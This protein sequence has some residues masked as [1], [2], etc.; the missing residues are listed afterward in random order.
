MIDLEGFL[1]CRKPTD[2]GGGRLRR[3]T[4]VGE[5]RVE[6]FL[7]SGLSAEVYRVTNLRFGQEGALKLLKDESRGLP[8]RFRAEADALRFLDIGALPKFLGCGFHEGVPYYVME[9]LQP[10]PEPMPRREIPSFMN[11]VAKAVQQLHDAGYIHRDLKPQNLLCRADGSPVLI[12]L[13]LVR[14]RGLAGGERF[15]RLG[16]GVS[17]IDGKA[18]GVGTLDYAAPEQ[19]LKGESSVQSDV[20]ALGKMLNSFYDDDPPVNIRRV[21]RRATREKPSDRYASANAFAAAIRHRNFGRWLWCFGIIVVLAVNSWFFH[22]P[23]LAGRQPPTLPTLPPTDRLVAETD[24]GYYNRIRSM[25]EAG[26]VDAQAITGLL[27]FHGTGCEKNLQAAYVW[28]KMASDNGSLKAQ[29]DLAFCLLHGFG[30][31]ADPASGFQFALDAAERGHVPAQ[32]LVGEC[33]LEGI[34]V[35]KDSER[36]MIWI[37]MAAKQGNARAI[38]LLKQK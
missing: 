15:H 12:D 10:L 37:R 31:A 21:I 1:Q 18:V 5:W 27:V 2:E 9:Y 26:D 25:A 22:H 33:Y 7:G 30:T 19:L 16:H 3:G 24:E 13:G 11:K 17:I 8:E 36:A 38:N 35:D 6:T 23:Y 32:T 29:A 20:F 14:K 28:F 34:G 4:T